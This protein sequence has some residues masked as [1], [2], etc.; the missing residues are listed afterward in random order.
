LDGNLLKHSIFRRGIVSSIAI[1]FFA[2]VLTLT[3]L[4]FLD[5]PGWII[6][7]W[8]QRVT[9][10]EQTPDVAL[11]LVDQNTVD[12][13]AQAEKITFPFPRQIYGI[14]NAVAA[15]VGARGVLYDILFTESSIYGVEDDQLFANLIQEAQIPTFM[16]AASEKGFVK[17][18]VAPLLP[19]VT[20]L[21]GVH[22]KVDVD[23]VLRRAPSFLPGPQG[24]IHSL[25]EVAYL[26]LA[27]GE[28]KE[29]SAFSE[30]HLL[31]FYRPD[32]I[33][34]VS[35]YDLI[36]AYRGQENGQPLPENIRGLKDRVLVVG[37][38]A[39]GLHD[40]K[41]IPTDNEAPGMLVPATAL[42]NRF[43]GAGVSIASRWIYVGVSLGF[44]LAI[45]FAGSLLRTPKLSALLVFGI[46][47]A[48]VL[49]FTYL[50]WMFGLWFNPFPL[51]FGVLVAG[52]GQMLVKFYAYWAD[53]RK[54]AKSLEYSMSPAMV[55]LI[56]NGQLEVE[57]YGEQREISILFCDIVG[58]TKISET[59]DPRQLVTL[60][61][62]Y[63]DAAVSLICKNG[64]YVDK[65]IGDAV[66]AFWG[67]PIPQEDHASRALDVA[68]AYE[69]TLKTFNAKIRTEFP[70]FPELRVRVG[71]HMGTAIVGNIGARNRH[72]Y[73]AIGDGVNL[74][75]RLEGLAK[76]YQ[77]SLLV[78]EDAVVAAKAFGRKG[79]CELDQVVVQGRTQPTR[80]YT[81]VGEDCEQD[82]E[83]YKTALAL[84]YQGRWSEAL[85]Y[86]ENAPKLPS[87]MVMAERCR[88][89]LQ[90]GN[91]K[92]WNQ[93]V[94]NHENK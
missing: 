60:L 30:R 42:A 22:F 54:F 53:R 65:F 36:L 25:P 3:T 40:L 48:L 18:P 6:Y 46:F 23:G 80:I 12:Q 92:E 15:K 71:L 52:A 20:G 70:K 2:F 24:E 45:L 82:V 33:P 50:C 41:S 13:M 91:L 90:Q 61:N 38:S 43:S 17:E 39:P 72:N 55:Q 87:S 57:R 5:R 27:K 1:L 37:Y 63:S 31:R 35:F 7:D 75:S 77:C 79:L 19:A 73:T 16:P 47:P 84:Y 8:L 58:F 32:G 34:F 9:A 85:G 14:V 88:R 78:S 86:F 49:L 51:G 29:R 69:T 74:A 44:L 26:T 67:A 81:F 56:K 89:T 28:K 59:L 83:S 66:M 94:W 64:G 21:G 10:L 62:L 68:I 11:I 4:Q 93:G 76:T